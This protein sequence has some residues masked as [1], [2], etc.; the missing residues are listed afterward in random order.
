M[1]AHISEN[2]YPNIGTEIDAGRDLNDNYQLMLLQDYPS[3]IQNVTFLHQ[4]QFSMEITRFVSKC[5]ISNGRWTSEKMWPSQQ[6]MPGEQET[7]DVQLHCSGTEGL[8]RG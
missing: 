1:R 8:E 4:Y 7:G 6:D 5:F 3:R 2:N